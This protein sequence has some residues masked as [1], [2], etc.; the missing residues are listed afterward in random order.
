MQER[1]TSVV[2]LQSFQIFLRWQSTPKFSCKSQKTG[3]GWNNMFRASFSTK[4]VGKAVML[5][6]HR[7]DN[8][9]CGQ[10]C[11]MWHN[12]S[13]HDA[14]SLRKTTVGTTVTLGCFEVRWHEKKD[15]AHWVKLRLHH[16]TFVFLRVHEF[17]SV[18][19]YSFCAFWWGEG[20]PWD[21][22]EVLVFNFF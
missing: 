10:R 2:V 18:G 21:L 19:P 20:D 8:N 14:Y 15:G 13:V 6:W 7:P 1:A 17:D 9:F 5:S 4:I 3:I 22:E 12:C 16:Q 11:S